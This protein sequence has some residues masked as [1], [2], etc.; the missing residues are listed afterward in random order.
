LRYRHD[1]ASAA[2]REAY[3]ADIVLQTNSG[4]LPAAAFDWLKPARFAP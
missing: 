1:A 4:N 2:A 3:Q